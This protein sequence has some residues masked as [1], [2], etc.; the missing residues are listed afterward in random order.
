MG[1]REQYNELLKE[2]L[3]LLRKYYGKNLVSV[4]LFGSVARDSFRPDSDIDLLIVAEGLP[5]GR[6]KRVEEFCHNVEGK[7]EERIKGLEAQGIYPFLSP[8][9]KTPEEVMHGSP[10]FLDMIYDA[11]ILYDK[12]GFFKSYL[13]QLQQRLQSLG[14]K[15]I[16]KGGGWYWVLKPDYKPGDRIEL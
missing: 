5:R 7:L 11:K 14:A 8:I 10:L 13:E 1:Y 15:R 3:A 4:V 6:I 16:F 12:G 2:L 9:F